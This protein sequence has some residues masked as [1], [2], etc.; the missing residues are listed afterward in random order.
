M[1][2]RLYWKHVRWGW[3]PRQEVLKEYY[4][5]NKTASGVTVNKTWFA[6][7]R[8]VTVILTRAEVTLSSSGMLRSFHHVSLPVDENEGAAG[9]G[10]RGKAG[11]IRSLSNM[12][13]LIL[14][15]LS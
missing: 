12:E 2:P 6:G 13:I 5:K 11:S 1:R 14:V 8:V 10:E 3:N 9:S 15:C 7:D 4:D